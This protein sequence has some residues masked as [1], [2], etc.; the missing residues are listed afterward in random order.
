MIANIISEQSKGRFGVRTAIPGHAQQGG[1][2]SSKDRVTASRYAVKCC[3]FIE[4]WNK[5]NQAKSLDS[6]AHILRF[7]FNAQG[8][9][10][11]TVENED[12]SAAVICVNGSKISFKPI[13]HLWENETNVKLRKGQEVHW[14]EFN[15]ISDILSGRLKLRA[16]VAAAENQRHF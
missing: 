2:P 16:E 6:D 3:K 9:K 8:E 4:N 10:I 7:T 11:S 12:D 5:K 13:A 14:T 1:V 15:K